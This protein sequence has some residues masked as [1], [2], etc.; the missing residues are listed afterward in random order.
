MLWI[1]SADTDPERDMI[2]LGGVCFFDCRAKVGGINGFCRRWPNIVAMDDTT[3]E[4][5]DRRWNELMPGEAFV[6]SPSR[7]YRGMLL[8]FGAGS[9]VPEL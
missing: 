2:I 3:I 1:A 7:R 8:P 5:I 9:E 6:E 4:A